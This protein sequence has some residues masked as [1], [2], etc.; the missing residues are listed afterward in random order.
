MILK[1]LSRHISPDNIDL[2]TEWHSISAKEF[3]SFINFTGEKTY[4]NFL[5]VKQFV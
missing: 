4:S 5:L 1:C 2:D 3:V